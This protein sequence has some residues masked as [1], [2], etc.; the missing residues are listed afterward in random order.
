M[1]ANELMIGDWVFYSKKAFP[2]KIKLLGE[3]LCKLDGIDNCVEIDKIH[4][5]LLTEEVLKKNVFDQRFH[6]SCE[7][8]YISYS[9]SNNKGHRI[10]I[11]DFKDGKL[12]SIEVYGFLID[13]ES[14][15]I[16][17]VHQFQHA[18]RLCGIEKEIE[19]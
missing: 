9:L 16:S 12:N 6:T 5:V 2:Y 7:Q 18:L 1:K 14:H 11:V 15:S 3:N 10:V 8:Q 17:S 4:P 13:I 19:L